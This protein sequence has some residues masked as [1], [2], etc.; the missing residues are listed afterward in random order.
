MGFEARWGVV[1]VVGELCTSVLA[2]GFNDWVFILSNTIDVAGEEEEK[3]GI[4]WN[5]L[6]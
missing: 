6:R 3:S 2:L 1:G 4:H 5:A